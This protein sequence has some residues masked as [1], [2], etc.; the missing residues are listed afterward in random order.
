[1]RLKHRG[2]L[3]GKSKDLLH[4]ARSY[5]SDAFPNP[6]RQG[7]PPDAA[8][9]SLAVDPSG[10]EA[11][12]TEH[13]ANCSPCFNRYS[14]LLAELKLGKSAGTSSSWRRISVWSTAH[15]LLVGAALVCALLIAV[16]ANLLVNCF[17]VPSPPPLQTHAGP[18][19]TEPVKTAVAFRLD[20]SKV[21]PIRGAKPPT[22]GSMRAIPVP[23]SPLDFTLTL[24]LGSEEGSY[25]VRL[26]A[27]DHTLWSDSAQAHLHN[28]Q[29]LIRV[30]AD[31]RQIPVGNYNLEVESPAG[32]RLTQPV[33][34]ETTSSKTTGQQP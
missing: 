20:L 18:S 28:A 1:M 7:C 14:E 32:V 26:R 29:I 24:P 19:S 12:L 13:L 17:N 25:V 10:S 27:G 4:F 31:F 16:G 21:S 33:L 8:L 2:G 5:L 3:E 30:Q 15:P 11:K 6:D 22:T 34:I 23:G 9:R